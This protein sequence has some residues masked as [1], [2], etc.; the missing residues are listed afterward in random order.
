MTKLKTGSENQR[1]SKV[2]VNY[3]NELKKLTD[4]QI[5]NFEKIDSADKHIIKYYIDLSVQK[6]FNY[7]EARA[8]ERPDIK[9]FEIRGDIT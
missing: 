3:L 2:I 5:S 4:N 8:G 7:K 6:E 1:M 9:E